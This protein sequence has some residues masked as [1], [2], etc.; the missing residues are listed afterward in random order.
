MKL[1]FLAALAAGLS[2]C[3]ITGAFA[4][5]A[6]TYHVIDLGPGF[7]GHFSS[8]G[9]L[10]GRNLTQVGFWR[11]RTWHLVANDGD[12]QF[13]AAINAAGDLAAARQVPWYLGGYTG[14]ATL[15][16]ANGTAVNLAPGDSQGIS[17]A[18]SINDAGLVVGFMQGGD[19]LNH[20]YAWQ[21]RKARALAEPVAGQTSIAHAVNASGLIVGELNPTPSTVQAVAYVH[22]AWSPIPGLENVQAAAYG[23][24][25]QGHVV[26]TI[27]SGPTTKRAWIHDDQGTRLLGLA[28]GKAQARAVDVN[29]SDVAV[30]ECDAPSITPCVFIGDQ[31]WDLALRVDNPADLEGYSLGAAV[32]IDAAGHIAVWAN[33]ALGRPRVLLWMPVAAD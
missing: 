14:A 26:G 28:E 30:G 33:N 16:H 6:P 13:T 12:N 1:R 7:P 19:R 24:N 18:V 25:T 15:Y 11:G 27:Y 2:T 32:S 8:K 22:G 4:Q 9:D 29:D 5:A 10:A 21:G 17:E 31:A 23:V 20:A 3:V